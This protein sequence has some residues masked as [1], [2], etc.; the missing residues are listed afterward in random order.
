MTTPVDCGRRTERSP[1]WG[2]ILIPLTGIAMSC[3]SWPWMYVELGI[4]QWRRPVQDWMM[5]HGW[6]PFAG[7]YGIFNLHI[8]DIVLAFAGGIVVGRVGYRRWLTYALLYAGGYFLGPYLV[9]IASGFP[10]SAFPVRILL[11]V[12]LYALLA[13][14]PFAVLGAWLGSNPKKR[15]REDRRA[16]GLCEWCGYD[17]TGGPHERC[18]ECGAA[19]PH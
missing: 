2:R 12:A 14:L 4:Q 8:P 9:S 18:P 5:A 6:G 3:L 19:S 16:A 15:R 1:W 17:L 10:Q 11:L 13:V 7:H